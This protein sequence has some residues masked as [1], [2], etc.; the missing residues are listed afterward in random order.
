MVAVPSAGLHSVAVCDQLR[1]VDK[2][3]L[4]AKIG[5][6][7]TSDLTAI[8]SGIAQILGLH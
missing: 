8:S 5:N 1:T 2:D 3:R 6:L 7:S 4:I